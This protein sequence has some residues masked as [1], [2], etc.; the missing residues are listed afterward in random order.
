[1]QKKALITGISGQDGY[2]LANLL[3]KKN[4]QVYG[5]TRNNTKKDKALEIIVTKLF[6][7]DL[8][9]E[10][11]INKV[12][13]EVKP[14]EIYHLAAYHFSSQNQE[15]YSKDFKKFFQTNLFI[16]QDILEWIKFNN[17]QTKLFYASTCQ[18]FGKCSNP[19]QNEN[20][21]YS[22]DSLYA[23]S[24]TAA[25]NLCS[26]YRIRHQIYVSVGILY[27]HESIRRSG[28]FIS[29]LIAEA[30]AK[31]YLNLPCKLE[32]NKINATV[33]WGS[34]ED[35]VE[36]IWLTLQQEKSDNY[37]ISTGVSH[38]VKEFIECAFNIINKNHESYV[39][40]RLS[41]EIDTSNEKTL[42]GD[43]SKIIRQCNWEP[44]I[45]FENM[46]KTMVLYQINKLKTDNVS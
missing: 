3:F 17:L 4:Y 45:S 10:G 44:R 9:E 29:T 23:I 13:S 40:Q 11:L 39:F 36:A 21:P 14:D 16:T 24:K 12:L 20:T 8:N 19:P 22:P 27:N 42:I 28:N 37:I 5:I 2:Y 43:N 1:M 7:Y 26:F 30:A 33:D 35:F 6:I 15:N 38:T 31:A 25:T 32:I 41:P 18:I 34:A 46:V